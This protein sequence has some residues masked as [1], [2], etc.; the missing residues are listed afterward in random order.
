M[1]TK[2]QLTQS[3]TTETITNSVQASMP[4]T[5]TSQNE[6]S[7]RNNVD[8]T[9][10]ELAVDTAYYGTQFAN[11]ELYRQRE[12]ELLV[13]STPESATVPLEVGAEDSPLF[14]NDSTIIPASNVASSASITPVDAMDSSQL[15]QPEASSSVDV[16]G[17]HDSL[18]GG[19]TDLIEST[20][21]LAG[22]AVSSVVDVAGSAVEGV[23]SVAGNAV[24]I[25]GSVAG[26]VIENAPDMAAGAVEAV[27]SIIG[28]IL[29]GFN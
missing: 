21:S 27:G 20:V 23:S 29:S 8:Y 5:G 28:A 19:A 2:D 16:A 9:L 14:L 24:E 11:N 22:N 4:P 6:E 1:F 17:L 12:A 26:A 25:A 10:T 18:A 3:T 15:F 13:S 7:N